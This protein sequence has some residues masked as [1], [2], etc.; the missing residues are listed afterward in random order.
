M[1]KKMGRIDGGEFPA[2]RKKPYA[3]LR[4]LARK[5]DGWQEKRK[6]KKK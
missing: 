3:S 5:R 1:G 2:E 4:K 6:K